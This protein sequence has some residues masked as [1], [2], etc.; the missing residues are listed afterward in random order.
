MY[1]GVRRETEKKFSC[2]KSFFLFYFILLIF[3]KVYES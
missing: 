1:V 2:H 3:M